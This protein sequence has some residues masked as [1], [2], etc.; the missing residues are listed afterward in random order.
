MK[1]KKIQFLKFALFLG[2][3]AFSFFGARAANA[4]T[5]N[6]SPSSGNFTVGNI[7][8]VSVLVN[9][10]GKAINSAEAVLNFPTAFL[11]IV[12]I[13]KSSSIF[14][15]WVEEPS[16]SNNAGTISLTGG[17]PTPGFNGSAGNIISI[18]FR[19]K[20]AGLASLVF[21]SAIVRANDGEG[22]N[23]LTS[24]ENAEFSLGIV[25]PSA[26]EA[27]TP[28]ETSG[29][30][31][32]PQISSPTHPDPNKWYAVNDAKFTWPLPSGTTGVRLL[33]SRIPNAIPTVTYIPAVN[34]RRASDLAD[35]TWYFSVRLKNN[36]GWGAVSHFRFQI[37]TET[38]KPFTIKF[39][40][41]N[42]T[43]N[44]RPTVVFDTTDSL[45]GINYY[46]IKIGEGDFFPVAPE[47]VKR[48]P[49]MLPIQNPGKRNILVQA[50]DNAEN[51]SVATEEFIIEPL[52]APVFTE[53]LKEL[54]SDQVLTAKG[55]TKY[56]N[57]QIIIWLQREKDDHKSFTVQSD[58]NGKF[59]FTAD[60]KLRD[61][62]YQLW[63][64]VVDARGAKSLPSEK[65]TI[66][67][68]KSAIFSV[69][70]WA[71]NFLAIIVPLV[72]LIFAL[73]FILW[74]GW[75]KFSMFRKKLKKEVREAESA[76]HRAFDLL[77]ED[78]REQ[79]K[80]LEKTK[81]RRELTE[82]EEKMIKQFKKDLDDAEKFVR[83]EIEDIEKEI[84]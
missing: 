5:L 6:F 44:P 53:Y 26:P 63:A 76:L 35:G 25:R 8:T 80:M 77:K 38:P 48:N 68:A 60:E 36:V 69:G 41:G 83:K 16:F 45:S 20:R 18:V 28:V 19:A 12:S 51:Y 37:D 55:E 1:D 50:Y 3:F 54:Q 61:G 67:V 84:K 10:Q 65:I 81:N 42:K 27:I 46:K 47:V 14:S 74:Y 30:P 72:V 43:S 24:S 32:A 23:I 39:I 49:Y 33:V 17:L 71:V 40:D 73:L 13:S 79:V 22:T 82:E 4:A 59:T 34:S 11:E 70:T 15:L 62:I 56:S 7:F 58:Q 2:L 31:A 66:A 21:S 9:T 75:H 52:D 29:V 78:I 64:E 57:S